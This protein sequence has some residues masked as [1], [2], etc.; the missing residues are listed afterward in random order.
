MD[1]RPAFVQGDDLAAATIALTERSV[2]PLDEAKAALI[3]ERTRT[4]SERQVVVWQIPCPIHA[5]VAKLGALPAQ[6]K[7]RQIVGPVVIG[8]R[9]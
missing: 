1:R 3:Q 8:M 5:R 4:V 9:H 7:I 2:A 6:P